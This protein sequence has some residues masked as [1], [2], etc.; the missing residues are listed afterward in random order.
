MNRTTPAQRRDFYRR[1]LGGETYQEIADRAAVSKECVRYWCRRQRDGGSCESRYHQTPRGLLT[2]LAPVVR[3]AILRLKLE[4]PRWGR[5]RIHHHLKKRVS[6][7]GR[8]LPHPS[9][10]GRYL[11]QWQ[12]FRRRPKQKPKRRERHKPPTFVHQRWQLDFKVN[13]EQDNG[14]KLALHTLVDQYSGACI[15]AQLLVKQIAVEK[16]ER[17]TWREAQATLRSGFALWNN[18]PQEVQTDN[19]TVLMGR[20]GADFPTDF[21]LWLKGLGIAHLAIRPG[22]STDNAE[23]ERGHRTI[24]EYALVGQ[25]NKPLS[26]LL[27]QNPVTAVH[28]LLPIQNCCNRCVPI[29]CN[30]SW[31]SLTSTESMTSW[32]LFAGSASLTRLAMSKLAVENDVITLVESM[33]INSV[34]SVLTRLTANWSLPCWMPQNRKSVVGRFAMYLT[35]NLSVFMTLRLHWRHSNF[36]CSQRC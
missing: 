27:E 36:L 17:V 31:L 35:Q 2:G 16:D 33:R 24:N 5:E 8:H 15:D 28:Q 25:E 14:D 10:I 7:R 30:R 22:K 32:P 18:L 9:S 3:F 23:V 29:N 6:C 19:E 34:A 26:C 11:H 1:H 13:I 20:P 21:S 4:H 12:R